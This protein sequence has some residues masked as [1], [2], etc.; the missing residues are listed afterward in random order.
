[1]EYKRKQKLT[2]PLLSLNRKNRVMFKV[3]GPARTA[4]RNGSEEGQRGAM[5]VYPGIDLETGEEMALL[6]FAV[7]ISTFDSYKEDLI[8]KCFELELIKDPSKDYKVV[9]IYELE[10]SETK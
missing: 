3:T 7:I 5:T 6:G 1:M 8:G 9:D 4:A 10:P 2:L